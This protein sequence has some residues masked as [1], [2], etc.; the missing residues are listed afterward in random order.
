MTWTG[1]TGI[2]PYTLCDDYMAPKS[3]LSTIYMEKLALSTWTVTLSL[4][5]NLY[6]LAF[7]VQSQVR[8]SLSG[9]QSIP[10]QGSVLG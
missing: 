10:N 3:L 5:A 7:A 9:S 2:P 4:T 6:S 8:L 1:D